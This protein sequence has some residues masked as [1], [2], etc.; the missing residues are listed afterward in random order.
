MTVE[1]ALRALA[2]ALG[3]RLEDVSRITASPGVVVV[4]HV[5]RNEAGRIRSDPITGPLIATSVHEWTIDDA[6]T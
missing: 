1:T 2:D 3:Y 5:L 6:T 4:E